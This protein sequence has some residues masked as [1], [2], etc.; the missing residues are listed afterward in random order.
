MNLQPL[1]VDMELAELSDVVDME[2]SAEIRPSYCVPYSGPYNV[3]P[4]DYTQVLETNG[5]R[6]TDDVTVEPI[7]S[8]YIQP[9]GELD[10]LQNGLADV[11]EYLS[12]DVSV[13]DSYLFVNGVSF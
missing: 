8:S 3:T 6:M 9:S 10:I 12:A 4:T 7:P 13:L 11:G 1:V 5:K 2:V